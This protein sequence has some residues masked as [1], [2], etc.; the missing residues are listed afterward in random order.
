MNYCSLFG[1]RAVGEMRCVIDVTHVL[2]YHTQMHCFTGSPTIALNLQCISPTGYNLEPRLSGLDSLHITSLMASSGYLWIG[3][4]IGV[5]LIYKIPLLEG[6]PL[7]S[8]K[9][10]LAMDGHREAVRVLLTVK[11]V[12]TVS[13]MRVSQFMSDERARNIGFL[14]RIPDGEYME[15]PLNT[16]PRIPENGE[17]GLKQDSLGL[18]ILPSEGPPSRSSTLPFNQ[19]TDEENGTQ[20]VT[21][22]EEEAEVM[23]GT[24][25]T[26]VTTE[27]QPLTSEFANG[28]SDQEERN[29]QDST[30]AS[31]DLVEKDLLV[32][33]LDEHPA[34]KETDSQVSEGESKPEDESKQENGME[35]EGD[36]GKAE[37][38]GDEEDG[39]KPE[40][41]SK[42]E[43][44][45]D[46][47]GDESKAEAKSDGS[48]ADVGVTVNNEDSQLQK[49]LVASSNL[50]A[51]VS[52]NAKISELQTDSIYSYPTE[53]D[54][55][56]RLNTPDGTFRRLNTPDSAAS[57]TTAS[58]HEYDGIAMDES[59]EVGKAPSP[60]EDPATLEHTGPVSAP[61]FFSPVD[62]TMP[63][64]PGRST[65]PH[66]GA[67]Y[68]LTAGRG[69]VNLRPG[70]RRSSVLF[71]SAG[72][73][74]L[75]SVRN[76]GC[77][78]AYEIF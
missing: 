11:T 2:F 66:E 4:S 67:V 38:E 74:S 55:F 16:L 45:E 37:A 39:R 43:G 42:P 51:E 13:S 60:Y 22:I 47:E 18:G 27:E 12:A 63:S 54:T 62:S 59:Y 48:E 72:N 46:G 5:I 21:G 50:T 24:E 1:S 15:T 28:P 3:T 73:A 77:M 71:P 29:S 64:I 76:E 23:A 61:E 36:D 56:R 30:E 7:V 9:P 25:N 8:G 19:H 40:D 68:V 78:I 65:Q 10:H 58:S 32:N 17:L 57:V 20:A 53:L 70:R 35:P 41:E 52:L 75:T 69:L 34:V 31:Q 14:E 33:G 26:V 44:K 6:V 49:P